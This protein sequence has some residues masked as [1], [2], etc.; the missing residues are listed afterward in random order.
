MLGRVA[1]LQIVR[2]PKKHSHKLRELLVNGREKEIFL[3]AQECCSWA[4]WI[5]E[6][7]RIYSAQELG[8]F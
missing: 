4:A 8:A 1:C 7:G 3:R 5:P 2:R 6:H